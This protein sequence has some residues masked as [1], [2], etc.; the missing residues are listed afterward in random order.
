MRGDSVFNI[1]ISICESVPNYLS[2]KILR[3]LILAKFWILS[4][5]KINAFQLKLEN[6]V[7]FSNSIAS[8]AFTKLINEGI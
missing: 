7:F 8:Y 5:P 3:I 4:E 6:P 1:Y 2:T